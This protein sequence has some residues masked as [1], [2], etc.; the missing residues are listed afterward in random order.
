MS[1]KLLTL[2]AAGLV[3]FACQKE[4]A[5]E[6]ILVTG[7]HLTFTATI[8]GAGTRTSVDGTKI[9]WNPAE[10]I[11]IFYGASE[12]SKFVSQNTEPSQSVTFSGTL[13]AFTGT[14][15]AGEP[16]SFWAIYPYDESN[17][18]SGSSVTA[19]LP[20][21]QVGVP[22]NVP[23][24]ALMMVA[25]ASGLA[26]SFKQVC[27]RIKVVVSTPGIRKIEIRGNNDETIAGSAV[28][29]MNSQG[30][31]EW[32]DA[33]TGAGKVIE[34][35]TES[36][37]TF[38]EAEYSIPIYPQTFSAGF[39]MTCYKEGE[40]G[41][42]STGAVTFGR[43]Q[44]RTINTNKVTEWIPSGE[45]DEGL[46][47]PCLTSMWNYTV[48][49]Q[50]STMQT[51]TLDLLLNS[52]YCQ[53]NFLDFRN[54]STEE[55]AANDFS[56]A[57]LV[58]I[59]HN[60]TTNNKYSTPTPVKINELLNLSQASSLRDAIVAAETTSG[61]YDNAVR[62]AILTWWANNGQSIYY[63]Q[64]MDAYNTVACIKHYGCPYGGDISIYNSDGSVKYNIDDQSSGQIGYNT[65]IR[66]QYNN[67]GNDL[68]YNDVD[69]NLYLICWKSIAAILYN[70]YYLKSQSAA[71]APEAVDLGLSVKWASFNLGA[72][73]PEE[74]GNY[75]AWGET[76]PISSGNWETY[77]WCMGAEG[78]LTKYCCESV[79][80]YNGFTDGK[81]IL[82]L[83]DDAAY[84]NLGGNWRMPTS[85]EL[86]ELAMACTKKWITLNGQYGLQLTSKVNGNS[87]FIP[88]SG[89]YWEEGYVHNSAIGDS[90]QVGRFW[91]SSL[92][93][94]DNTQYGGPHFCNAIAG[95]VSRIYDDDELR[96]MV[97]G[98]S[99]RIYGIPIRPVFDDP[100]T[101]HVE[102]VSLDKTTLELYVGFSEQL[103]A[104][105]F[106][107]NAT[108]QTI[109][110][111]S[112]DPSIA[113]VDSEGRVTGIAVGTTS[114]YAT[115]Y[116]GRISAS[117]RVTVLDGQPNNVIYY[118]S[119]DG[120]AIA[121][122]DV[123]L[124]NGS[125]IA[126]F[127]NITRIV[128]N[129]YNDGQGIV[130]FNNEVKYIGYTALKG[131]ST[132]TS[133]T[134][135]ESV[136]SIG[137]YAF[138]NCNRLTT[139]NIPDNVSKIGISAFQGCSSLLSINI[140]E[141]VTSI[142][143]NAFYE[144][145][146]LASITIPESVT[147]IGSRAFYSCKN[148]TSITIPESITSISDAFSASGLT[149]ITIPKSVTCLEVRA[150][151]YCTNL[152]SAVILGATSV[153]EMAFEDCTSLTSIAFPHSV[154]TIGAYAFDYCTSLASISI[155]N[156][157][158]SI[159]EGAFRGCSSLLSIAIPE[160]VTS[161]GD[162]VFAKCSSLRSFS[163]KY[164][165][166]N[167][168]YLIDQGCM[169]AVASGAMVGSITIPEG[170]SSIGNGTFGFCSNLA[171]IS[172]PEGVSSIGNRAFES[173]SSLT[174]II[175]PESVVSIGICAFNSC[176]SLSSI[177]L[178]T[179]LTSIGTSTFY[180]CTRLTSITI[181]ETV[182]SIGQMAFS[183][184]ISLVSITI[185]GSVSSIGDRAFQSCQG[186]N[187]IIVKPVIP[188]TVGDQIFYIYN[189]SVR[190]P[191]YVP[192]GSVEA[193]K[194][195]E[196]WT[197]YS[198][199][200]QAILE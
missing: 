24:K 99:E 53:Y 148:L 178:P 67:Q 40:K 43:N 153:K 179:G 2:M 56:N 129:E 59:I 197:R 191:I 50:N 6:D 7:N 100:T 52:P 87:I 199:R 66:L 101:T 136:T 1:H 104:T 89:Y 15:E 198:N 57:S 176:S 141:G 150:F 25:K 65:N 85:T 167:G 196:G 126:L 49:S 36:G 9:S 123:E 21:N 164:A 187:S 177:D 175:I 61:V 81:Y 174:S 194:S 37:T 117:C 190:A 137:D 46:V 70:T 75:Y 160:S 186:L 147:S 72:T 155:P 83:E 14:T 142:Q 62:D 12:G 184:C 172:I 173:C 131:F 118:T 134:I 192:S 63:Q 32:Q 124:Y 189:D 143:N 128:S 188:P 158:T 170:V 80:G 159:G 98:T 97:A 79:Y 77:K 19:Y 86:I 112:N 41:F 30:L 185:P 119:S 122:K 31:P 195:A 28:I 69:T 33:G 103:I 4:G 121:F 182:T 144:C 17:S 183:G 156:S 55:I 149:N 91:T 45:H 8:D 106:P 76:D 5:E 22:N 35:V 110:W 115:N 42:Y 16:N 168:L 107:S 44:V 111:K 181:P 133:I 140:P 132:L 13:T 109:V 38:E 27:A 114:I 54:L 68:Y 47:D 169:I 78:T 64:V 130:T 10:E 108:Y 20:E 165:S 145:R 82:E 92:Y 96:N 26:L 120:K 84:M 116:E 29:T 139:V 48:S 151:A 74:Y 163:G 166:Q 71:V 152:T 161:I 23:D 113:T 3:L 138:Q 162:S 193:Y 90:Y 94:N 60:E 18:S 39:T 180:D 171:E 146:S 58:K 88:A 73:T 51:L 34:L 154:T 95:E 93:S 135:P 200:I 105:V 157:V 102:S 11:N 125:Q 127:G